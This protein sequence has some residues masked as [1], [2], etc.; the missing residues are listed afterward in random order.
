MFK[1]LGLPIEDVVACDA[2]YRR[3]VRQGAGYGIK[4]P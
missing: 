1:S 2:I 4:F 3:A